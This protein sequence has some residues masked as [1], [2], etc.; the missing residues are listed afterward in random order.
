VCVCVC[1]CVFLCACIC[2]Y[3]NAEVFELVIPHDSSTTTKTP[4]DSEVGAHLL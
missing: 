3:V 1:V 4:I 2:V